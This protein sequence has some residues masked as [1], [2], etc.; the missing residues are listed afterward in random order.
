LVIVFF[1]FL[2]FFPIKT[3]FYNLVLISFDY[4]LTSCKI[5]QIYNYNYLGQLIGCSELNQATLSL[6]NQF[7]NFNLFVR[8]IHYVI[9]LATVLLFLKRRKNHPNLKILDWILLMIFCF[10]V[11][12]ALEYFANMIYNFSDAISYFN[13]TKFSFFVNILWLFI[14]LYVL[15]FKLQSSDR[16]QVFFIA[17]PATI[18]SFFLWFI[19]FG[20]RILPLDIS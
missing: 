7:S 17:L 13:A 15:F 4:I 19:Y 12:D 20:P 18:L 8:I 10:F 6:G 3:Q 16:L 9:A 11:V 5:T 2:L 14:G 1:M